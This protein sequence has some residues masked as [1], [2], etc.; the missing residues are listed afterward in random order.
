MAR[1]ADELLDV[2]LGSVDP[3]FHPLRP[4]L[5]GIA[6]AMAL[7]EADAETQMDSAVPGLSDGVWLDLVAEGFGLRRQNGELDATLKIRIST[8]T[9]LA[10]TKAIKDAVDAILGNTGTCVIV[11]HHRAMVYACDGTDAS[12]GTEYVMDAYC[13]EDNF[14]GVDKGLTVICPDG[15]TE[16]IELAICA[17]I[18]AT[19]ALGIIATAM[20][21]ND[22]T[23]LIY[24]D[25]WEEA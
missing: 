1:T 12:P 22:Y 25:P 5:S 21:T 3:V 16:A 8:P 4:L 11:E 14:D 18:R 6:A 15:L 10:T 13:D 9:F 2:A 17:V 19:K 23:D 20:F 7:V 24:G